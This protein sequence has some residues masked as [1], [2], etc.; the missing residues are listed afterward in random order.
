MRAMVIVK[1]KP[2]LLQIIDTL[3]S[4]GRFSCGLHGR[5]QQRYENCDNRN[6]HQQF[7]Q[8]E[9]AIGAGLHSQR[10]RKLEDVWKESSEH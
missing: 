3:S 5:K 2:D 8:R 1:T 7:D 4:T 10:P 6:H 9:T